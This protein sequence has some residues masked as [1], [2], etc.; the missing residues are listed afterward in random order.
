M[1]TVSTAPVAP[2]QGAV[3]ASQRR[4]SLMI[5]LA[6]GV[7]ILLTGWH[8][9]ALIDQSRQRE[10]ASAEQ[11]L[12]N[13]TRLTEEHAI[14]TLR[15]AD[16]V[17]RFVQSRYLE[18]GNR[19]DL[20]DLTARGVIDNEIFN[21]VGII[22]AKGIYILSNLPIASH[23]DLSDRE[24]FKVHVASDAVGLF[25]SQPVLGRASGK[26][27]IQMTRRITLPN[28]DFGGVVVV[29]IVGTMAADV[30]HVGLG[31][32]YVVSTAFWAIVLAVVF[33]AWRRIEGSLSIHSVV[34]RRRE[35]F[36]WAAVLA[37]FALGTAAGDMTAHTLGLGFLASGILFTVLMVIP[38]VAYRTKLLGGVAAFWTAYVLTRPIGASFADYLGMPTWR[39]GLGIGTGVVALVL[40]ALIV[41]CV[42]VL[43][44]T[45][46]DV[47]SPAMVA[48]DEA[49]L[50]HSR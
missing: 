1:T 43:A 5:W 49:G 19:L 45:K 7:L 36:Y 48:A 24:H 34:T 46:R 31:I 11:D 29:S 9:Y 37:T 23:V 27:S 15:S 2:V 25:V 4:I 21:Q 6:A 14:R 16:Q 41:V 18:L 12:G 30:L 38:I 13:L 17:I 32:P 39:G 42:A 22:D 33:V 20:K 26:W 47:E 10:L 40:T 8:A 35:L 3:I 28:G 50:E 44:I